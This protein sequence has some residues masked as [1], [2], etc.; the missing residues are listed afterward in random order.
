V[1][2][3]SK[4]NMRWEAALFMA[5][6]YRGIKIAARR[7]AAVIHKNNKSQQST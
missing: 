6:A 7:R 4:I 3:A 2:P 5:A 1:T